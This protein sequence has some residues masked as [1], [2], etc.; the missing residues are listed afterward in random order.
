MSL[1]QLQQATLAAR[2]RTGDKSIG[3]TVSKGRIQIVKVTYPTEK[4]GGCKVVKMTV[5][6]SMDEAVTYLNAL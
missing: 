2:A 1:A 6:L 5:W 4:R 3:T